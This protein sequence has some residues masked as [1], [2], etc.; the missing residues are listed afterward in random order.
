M[1]TKFEIAKVLMIVTHI[2]RSYRGGIKVVGINQKTIFSQGFRLAD[3]MFEMTAF[4]FR[5]NVSS[6]N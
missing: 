6:E 1:V 2:D 4:S 3:I 5:S